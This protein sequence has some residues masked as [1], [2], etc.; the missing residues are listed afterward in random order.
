MRRTAM[1]VALVGLLVLAGVGYL[2]GLSLWACTVRSLA[3]AAALYVMARLALQ[4]AL[5]S[6]V[7]A[8]VDGQSVEAAGK[9]SREHNP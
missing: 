1:T 9:K 2:S 6:F 7:S 8:I 4:L 3:G 5:A